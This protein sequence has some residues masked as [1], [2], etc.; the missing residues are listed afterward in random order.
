MDGS[1]LTKRLIKQIENSLLKKS[2]VTCK[3][4]KFIAMNASRCKFVARVFLAATFGTSKAVRFPAAERTL[5]T[6]LL[7]SLFNSLWHSP[8]ASMILKDILR[9]KFNR[10]T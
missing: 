4:Q 1:T 3:L 7:P 10:Y 9:N 2:Y 6:S 8:F 5:K